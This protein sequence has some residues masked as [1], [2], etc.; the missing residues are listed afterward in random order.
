MIVRIIL[1]LIFV[2]LTAW[3]S[4][5]L[6]NYFNKREQFKSSFITS[7]INSNGFVILFASFL[8]LL[9]IKFWLPVISENLLLKHYIV[10]LAG[11]IFLLLYKIFRFNYK[12][13]L[14]NLIAAC[15][16]VF[17]NQDF[18]HIQLPL[19][20]QIT[21]GRWTDPF[22]IGWIVTSAF[23]MKIYEEIKGLSPGALVI[24]LTAL[25]II[26][27][28]TEQTLIAMISAILVFAIVGTLRTSL[29]K[30]NCNIGKVYASL[31]GLLI[32]FIS[33]ES[34]RVGDSNTLNILVPLS[35]MA[36]PMLEAF[37][38]IKRSYINQNDSK[39]QYIHDRLV[40]LGFSHRK[41]LLIIF[42]AIGMTG[43]VGISFKW[44]TDKGIVTLLFAVVI[45]LILF[46][47]R[48]GYLNLE[49]NMILIDEEKQIKLDSNEYVAFD[50]SMFYQKMLFVFFDAV[51]I[52]SAFLLTY[53]LEIRFGVPEKFLINRGEVVLWSIWS[54]I[55]WCSMFGL[56]DL[57][58]IEWDASRVEEIFSLLKI[59]IVGSILIYGLN[60]LINIPVLVTRGYF[61]IYIVLLF[62]SV[63]IGRL[64]LIYFLR[65]YDLLEFSDR[66]T[67]I[68]GTGEHANNI[69]NQI[70]NVD[71]LKFDMIGFIRDDNK[72]IN[73]NIDEDSIIGKIK[74]IPKILRE[75]EIKEA[76]I[77]IEDNDHDKILNLVAVLDDF[78]I[79]VKV[80]PDYYNILTGFRT[81]YIH[82]ISLA[83]FIPNNMKTWEWI[84]K[85][86]VDI[87]LSLVVLV[88]F[89]P[90]WMIVG[91][92]IK[93]ESPGPV[94]YTQTRVGR[95]KKPYTIYK[96]RS[97]VANAEKSGAQW[98]SKNDSRI[99]K[100]G[101]FL[102]KSG[103]DEIP[104]FFNVLMGDM[105]VVGPR[106]ERPVFVEELD[107][108]VKFYTRRLLVKPGITGW[109]QMKY[110]Y[111]QSIE[112]VK[113]KVKD[114]LYY[115]SNMSITLDL[116]IIIQTA[117]TV[118]QKWRKHH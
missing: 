67:I 5:K 25:T 12:F 50:K 102:R 63:S 13:L 91:I 17:T 2:F 19:I 116:K 104:Q 57:Y 45:F 117:L 55:F 7:L 34:G 83:K 39:G 35:I 22:L 58:Q 89:L 90:V 43:I 32:G 64:L 69:Y 40:K 113:Q 41:A 30:L 111:D 37:M 72:E 46:I 26:S 81:S 3:I 61:M 74:N 53:F 42:S 94:L 1:S 73:K 16:L 95:N 62:I 51:F 112:D 101:H 82:G 96:F 31:L 56:N 38:I 71:I 92:I 21:M 49:S 23:A 76:I 15:V 103:I 47:Y 85:R 110:Q 84:L 77:A 36:M 29:F 4:K 109:A 66:P 59:V 33:L 105:S 99:T 28:Q 54:I 79:S 75:R 107:E 106:P 44:I 10:G 48:L 60:Y 18:N 114:D 98:A 88:G 78:N 86:V 6:I 14:V 9:L 87:V 100:F 70:R 68:I 97:M 11:I 8:G 65:R 108:K 93:L 20:G 118:F 80:I 115:I 27:F 52:I 24:I